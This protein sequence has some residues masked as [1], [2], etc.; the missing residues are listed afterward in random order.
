MAALGS[1]GIHAE[2][3][4]SVLFRKLRGIVGVGVTWGVIWAALGA[5]LGLVA[6]AVSPESV[7]QGEGPAMF[8]RVLGIA[9]FI[10]GAG[11][12]LM[13]SFLERGRTVLDVSLSR[14]AVW[15]AVGGAIVPL[16]TSVANNQIFWTCPLGALLA[17]AA[18]GVARRAER[19]DRR[20][21]T[22]ATAGEA[23][24]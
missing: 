13:L 1:R 10:S 8:A 23:V 7:D 6:L 22:E 15:G 17:L 4:V 9:G 21:S 14:V 19:L 16:V 3:I 12:G 11:F 24:V 2:D 18:A 20:R 5:L